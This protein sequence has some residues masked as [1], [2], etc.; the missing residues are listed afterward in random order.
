MI[1]VLCVVMLLWLVLTDG[2]GFQWAFGKLQFRSTGEYVWFLQV[3]S[4]SSLQ[5]GRE[6]ML[7]VVYSRRVRVARPSS[8]TGKPNLVF[9]TCPPIGRAGAAGN[10]YS[11]RGGPQLHSRYLESTPLLSPRSPYT[12]IYSLGFF[13]QCLSC[14][15][16]IALH[17]SQQSTAPMPVFSFCLCL[18][19]YFLSSSANGSLISTRIRFSR[20][21]KKS[22]GLHFA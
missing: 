14:S 12:G 3:S 7:V 20:S 1:D 5:S 8:P 16:A 18:T 2:R 10:A 19:T 13:L 15:E 6:E 11:D 21:S 4:I 9:E 22:L 17:T